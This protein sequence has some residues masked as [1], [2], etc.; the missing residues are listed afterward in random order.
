MTLVWMNSRPRGAFL[1]LLL[2]AWT[3]VHGAVAD[4]VAF[5]GG[6]KLSGDVLSIQEDGT[7]R[8]T[9]PL[10][11]EPLVLVGESIERI[12]F[13]ASETLAS[14]GNTRF[15]L[16]GGDFI[17]GRLISHSREL[18]TRV[19]ADGIGELVLPVGSV[20]SLAMATEPVRTIYRG[21][22]PLADWITDGRRGAQHWEF[23]RK[24]LVA[25]NNGQIGRMLDLPDRYVLRATMRWQ[26]YPNFQIGFSDPLDASHVRVDR[27]YLQFGRAGLEIKRESKEGKRYHTI[28]I[29]NRTPDQFPEQKIEIEI[30]V[31]LLESMIHLSINGKQEGRFMDPFGSPPSAGG[32]LL[33]NNAGP[34]QQLEVTELTVETWHEAS[35]PLPARKQ[36]AKADV[37]TLVMCDGDSFGGVLESIESKGDEWVFRMKVGFRD[38]PIDLSGEDISKLQFAMDDRVVTEMETDFLLQLR[39]RG[40]LSVTH[41]FFE[42][43][44]IRATHPLLGD[45]KIPRNAVSSMLSR[46]LEDGPSS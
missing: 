27:Y 41:S 18:G 8:M 38:A 16:A 5:A 36:A 46:K 31:D 3:G 42:S 44:V 12:G 15:D 43:G 37:D 2:C 17:M 1:W 6:A 30:R 26:E 35:S 45:L 25:K 4:E 21:P 9:S 33:V 40:R 10:A 29:L 34:G 13:T 22:D 19:I 7:I 20:R 11:R 39:D 32:I 24:R 28:G 14:E 23:A